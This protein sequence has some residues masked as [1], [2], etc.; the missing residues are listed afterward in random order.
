MNLLARSIPIMVAAAGIA[1][2]SLAPLARAMSL[3]DESQGFFVAKTGNDSNPGTQASP[4][5]TIQRGIDAAAASSKKRVLVGLGTFVESV[6]LASGVKLYGGFEADWQMRSNALST[7]IAPAAGGQPGLRAIDLGSAGGT[8]DG[9]RVNAANGL[10]VGASSIGVLINNSP[11]L[12]V[13]FVTVSAGT[14]AAGA[15]AAPNAPL[16]G[17]PGGSGGSG[18]N[19]TS[20]TAPAP[21]GLAG[22]SSCGRTGGGGG[23]GGY[24]SS[25]GISGTGGAGGTLGGGGGAATSRCFNKSGSGQAGG[26]GSNGVAGVGGA[27][28]GGAAGGTFGTATATGFIPLTAASGTNGTAGNGGGGGGG[29]GG[30]SSSNFCVADRG[31]GGGGGGAGGCGGSAGSGGMM[32][33]NSIGFYSFNS[34][35]VEIANSYVFLGNGGKGGNGQ[36]GSAGGIG[37]DPGSIGTGPDDAGNG[38]PGGRGGNGGPAGGG[39]AG[40]GGATVAV[41]VAGT[42]NVLHDSIQFSGGQ[43]GLGGTGG[44]PNGASAGNGAIIS[45]QGA[46]SALTALHGIFVTGIGSGTGSVSSDIGYI[47]CGTA[48]TGYYPLNTLVELTAT[49]GPGSLFKAWSGACTGTSPCTLGTMQ[50]G[51]SVA[52]EFRAMASVAATRMDFNANRVSDI[53]YRN[54]A[55]GQLYRLVMN[56]FSTPIGDVVYDETNLAWSVANSGDFNGDGITDLV[57]RNSSTGEVYV[58]LFGADG[59]PSG[60][61][62]VHIETNPDWRIVHT[63]DFDGDGKSDLLWWNITTGQAYGMMMDGASI[64]GQGVIH[65][66]PD[67]NW[68]I[69]AF[70]DFAGTGKSNQ[71]LYRHFGTGALYMMTVQFG[72]GAFSQTGQ[73]IYTESNVAWQVIGAADLNA[74]GRSDILWRN[75]ATGQVYAMLMQG[76]VIAEQTVVYT[77]ANPD[78]KIVAMGDYDGDAKAD[79]LWRN[80]TTGQVYLVRM[81]GLAVVGQGMVY[82]ES[83]TSWKVLGP[84]LFVTAA[85]VPMP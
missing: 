50:G 21:G 8:L 12:K 31:G 2:A 11:G 39:G 4:F 80:E 62:V 52:A 83:N 25:G 64:V 69:V 56:G 29:G 65:N 19:G 23:G 13:Q 82:T 59:R 78:W 38:G 10:G 36:P 46:N 49:P 43:V 75:N 81:N 73:V 68:K 3:T 35:N 7:I 14:G 42:G 67:T 85:G 41:L 84:R 61:T 24:D 47:R 18:T 37:G 77:E 48:C 9:L 40:G 72:G 44:A 16:P 28:V 33:G 54:T 51:F 76:V 6:T 79:L 22:T 66:E 15:N 45:V 74:D 5:L 60:G 55:T 57:W 53:M 27:F 20:T 70:G 1:A 71:L 32:G 58:M 30:G 63:P 34:A 26:N 17:A